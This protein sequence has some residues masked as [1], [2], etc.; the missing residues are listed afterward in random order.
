MRKLNTT[1]R[2]Q[3]LT[4]L[5][6]G[7]SIA[8]TCRMFG[9]SKITVLR[10]LADAG[11]LAADYHDLS[12]RELSTKRVQ[13]DEIWAFV[14]SKAINVKPKNFGEGHGDV[15]TWVSLDADSK[16]AINW[17]VGN[18]NGKCANE[19]VADMAER[20]N[21]RVQLTSDGFG[22][23]RTAVAN[24]F[25]GEVDYAI[26]M[27]DYAAPRNEHARYSPPICIAARP[28]AM[29]GAPDANHINTSYVE[30]QNLSMR[31]GMRRF[32]RLTNGFSKKLDNHKYMIALYYFHY[33][34]I[35]KHQTIKTTP[36]LRA[37]IA[38][39]EW[40]MI[41]FV[42]MLEREEELTGGR[43]TDYKPAA[44]KKKEGGESWPPFPN[45]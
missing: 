1:Q 28:V 10:L 37:N 15:W 16:L 12:V 38:D 11:S 32:T 30:R 42:K 19:F 9:V 13:I 17:L 41:D 26:L 21:D 4:A 44:S 24:A 6:E 40:T 31:M 2:A 25:G 29:C 36:A 7:N 45:S 3:I 22:P 5:V 27:K 20:L 23:Y 43:L 35:R 18:R 39:K 8:S 34:F 33:N 14:H